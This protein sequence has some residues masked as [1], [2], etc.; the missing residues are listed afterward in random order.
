[1]VDLTVPGWRSTKEACGD[2]AQTLEELSGGEDADE[3]N[4]VYEMMDNTSFYASSEDEGITTIKKGADEKYHVPGKLAVAPRELALRFLANTV[5]AVLAGRADRKIFITPLPRYLFEACCGN[6]DH[7]NTG[8]LEAFPKELLGGLAHYWRTAKEFFRCG[9]SREVGVEVINPTW[10]LAGEEKT[11]LVEQLDTLKDLQGPQGDPVHFS[12]EGYFKMGAGI[13]KI[14]RGEKARINR[15]R[16]REESSGEDESRAGSGRNGQS[17]SAGRR[18]WRGG[19]VGGRVGS[20]GIPRGSYIPQGSY[21]PRRPYNPRSSGP[22][23]AR[24][25]WGRG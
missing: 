12:A 9:Q 11:T 25:R 2:L 8:H 18:G 13:L 4:V 24:G 6:A 22:G 16:K 3:Y 23:R 15:K 10:L 17:T 7:C 19:W 1:V 21:A 5:P 20:Y 14:A